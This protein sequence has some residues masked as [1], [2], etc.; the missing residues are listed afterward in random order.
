M[1]SLLLALALSQSPAVT[2]P[3]LAPP[4]VQPL[5]ADLAPPGQTDVDRY[6]TFVEQHLMSLEASPTSYAVQVKGRMFKLLDAD[7][8]EAFALV[9]AAQVRAEQAQAAL[10]TSLV[11]QVVALSLTGVALVLTVLAPL[12]S[13]ALPLFVVALALLAPALVLSLVAV[14]FGLSGTQGFMRAVA[15]YNVGLTRLRPPTFGAP[16]G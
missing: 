12:T 4:V 8:T 13:V 10:R 11:L 15:D 14:P 16:P 9:P 6:A 3:P 2:P 5:P 1:T 7:F